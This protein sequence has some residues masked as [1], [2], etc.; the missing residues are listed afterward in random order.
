MNKRQAKISTI[1]SGEAG[2]RLATVL[3]QSDSLYELD[4]DGYRVTALPAFSCL[5]KPEPGD[6]VLYANSGNSQSIIVSI[7]SRPDDQSMQLEFPQHARFSAR[8]GSIQ[9]EAE[10]SVSMASR[11]IHSVCESNVQKSDQACWQIG[12]L[13]AD[14]EQANINFKGVTVITNLL[15]T[16]ARQVVSK[17]KSYLRH[18]EDIDQVKSNNMTR[19]AKGLLN[20]NSGH[21][22]ML[23]KKDTK[24]DA[25]RI[26]IG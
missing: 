3:Q 15:S 8:Q 26:H 23:S 12:Q 22:V 2:F 9:M 7:I 18:S 11:R 16:L 19:S 10:Q 6:Q 24:I 25:A 13:Q 1:H 17:C 14:G 4:D 20:M 21:T 5:V